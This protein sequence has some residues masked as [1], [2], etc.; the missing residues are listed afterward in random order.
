MAQIQ[1]FN[2]INIKGVTE[3]VVQYLRVHIITGQLSPG[4][5]LS[6]AELSSL[7]GIS[8]SPL[9][10]AFRILE[11]EQ[12]V[13]SIPR[14]GCYVTPI[15]WK[16]CQEIYSVREMIELFAI[17]ILNAKEIRHLTEVA[18]AITKASDL[19]MPETSD[20]Y[21]MYDYLKILSSFHT[22]LVKTADNYLLA[23][24][25]NS[26][27]PSLARYRAMF[28]YEKATEGHQGILDLIEQSDY[29]GAKSLLK[30]HIRFLLNRIEPKL[31]S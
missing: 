17:D 31:G 28:I 9:R 23:H 5:R 8:R 10:E 22:K 24:F 13:A 27:L 12:L 19:T 25:Y 14:K 15:S 6:E 2:S 18:A 11:N 26:I 16:S 3:S 21:E 7:L 30:A 4:Q 1:F 29:E 20:P